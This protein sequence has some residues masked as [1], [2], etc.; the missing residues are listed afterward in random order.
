VSYVII[1]VRARLADFDVSLEEAARD[2]GAGPWQV[3]RRVTLPLIKPGVINGA[4]FAFIISFDNVS[5]SL[6]LKGVA[7]TGSTSQIKLV[8]N[9]SVAPTVQLSETVAAGGFAVLLADDLGEVGGGGLWHGRS[10][11]GPTPR[12]A[13]QVAHRVA[14]RAA[15]LAN[16]PC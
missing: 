2:L 4:L 10:G 9:S 8:P 3:F 5:I 12:S 11:A 14:I 13:G 15:A 16:I 1:T 6:L 7:V